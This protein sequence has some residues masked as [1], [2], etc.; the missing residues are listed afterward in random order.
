MTPSLAPCRLR[1]LFGSVA[2]IFSVLSPVALV[3]AQDV[4]IMSPDWIED[5]EAPEQLPAPKN[6]VAP[7][8]PEAM[9]AT[10][11]PGYVVVETLLDKSGAVISRDYHASDDVYREVAVRAE[12]PVA[13]VAG[14]RSGKS[15]ITETAH[16][17]VFNPASAGTAQADATPRLLQVSVGDLPLEMR[18]RTK[19]LNPPVKVDATVTVGLDGRIT[20]VE[21]VD[22]PFARVV[23]VTA[24][25]WRFAPARHNG[26]P[27]VAKIP[28]VFILTEP[29]GRVPLPLLDVLPKVTKQVPPVYPMDMRIG[30]MRA[31]VNVGFLVDIE[32]GVR[33]VGVLRSSNPRFDDAAIEAVRKWRF[34][35]GQ[36]NGRVVS[37][38]QMVPI[39]FKILDTKDG[40]QGPMSVTRK[41][42]M[43]K[44]PEAFRYDTPPEPLGYLPP[45]YPYELLRDGK[46][47]RAVVAYV[48]DERGRVV[49][50]T[51][52]QASRPEFG[53]ALLAAVEA[54]VFKPALKAGRPCKAVMA[55][56]ETFD[57]LGA[58][59]LVRN[60]DIDL[61]RQE[62]RKSK[63]IHA[64]RDVDDELQAT[65]RIPPRIPLNAASA[66]GQAEIAFIVDA[67]GRARLPRIVSST[68]DVFGYAAV[69]AVSTWR[70]E[71]PKVG[72]KPAAVRVR[73]PFNFN[74]DSA[75]K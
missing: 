65:F 17:Y 60:E 6:L 21:G 12:E 3:W 56:E 52:K 22:A 63:F 33:Q 59:F 53:S 38:V 50:A 7:A 1:L 11:Q 45:V 70:F 74:A 40:G 61:L 55:Y 42:D 15:V 24:K 67:T 25:N 37:A 51:V 26:E 73:V 47:G 62:K 72:G 75:P 64:A 68:E 28:I 43:S 16:A 54:F 48:V 14:K 30:E 35:P 39:L 44:L 9:R 20:A 71:P 5:I 13:W 49:Q 10:E 36:R 23:A 57:I 41:G 2:A 58:T 29:S 8:F 34:E 19:K 4:S 27:I 69:Q 66:T 32:G 18:S 46:K 31:E